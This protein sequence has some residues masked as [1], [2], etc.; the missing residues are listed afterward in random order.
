MPRNRAAGIGAGGG[1]R[2]IVQPVLERE[3]DA[4]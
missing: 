4:A 3:A 1:C 2:I